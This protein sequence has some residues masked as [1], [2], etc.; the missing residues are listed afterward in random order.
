MNEIVIHTQEVN[1]K[2]RL[3]EINELNEI[4][5]EVSFKILGVL[6]TLTF[7]KF[8]EEKSYRVTL[9]SSKE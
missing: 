3:Y 9:V 2:I 6:E 5:K 1:I 8:S 7:K 4:L